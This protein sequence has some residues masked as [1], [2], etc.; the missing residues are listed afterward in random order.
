[1]TGG[2]VGIGF[3]DDTD[4]ALVVTHDGRGVIDCLTGRKVARD[5]DILYPDE[6]T[7]RI[8][9]I[10]PLAGTAVTVA[11]IDGGSL[12]HDTDDGWLLEGLFSNSSDDV[13]RLL[14]PKAS[15]TA[16][17]ATFTGFIPEVRAFGFSPT[18]RSFVIATGAEVFV[19]SRS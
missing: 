5:T 8:D 3:G 11:G 13:I 15:A 9:G 6:H 1:M 10:G 12:R 16:S 2:L 4:L 14:P 18:G 17:P 19:Y 7:L